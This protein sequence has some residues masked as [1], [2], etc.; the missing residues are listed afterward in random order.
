MTGCIKLVGKTSISSVQNS[1]LLLESLIGL[2]QL[3]CSGLGCSQSVLEVG[4]FGLEGI[5]LSSQIGDNSIKLIDLILK[6][7]ISLGQLS[8]LSLKMSNGRCKVV[9]FE[10]GLIEFSSHLSNGS[11]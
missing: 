8:D 7:G 11:I 1:N 9:D 2:F 6:L 5:D 4:C 10:S 3:S